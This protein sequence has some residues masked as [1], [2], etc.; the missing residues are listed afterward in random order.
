MKNLVCTPL[1][2]QLWPQLAQACGNLTLEGQEGWIYLLPTKEMLNCVEKKL[3]ETNGLIGCSR[4]NLFTL[5]GL[6]DYVLEFSD[7][8]LHSLEKTEALAVLAQVIRELSRE[9]KLHYFANAGDKLGYLEGL[10]SAIGE[11][12]RFLISPEQLNQIIV[13]PESAERLGEF[14]EIYRLYQQH[15]EEEHLAQQEDLYLKA[16]ELL[17]LEGS[18]LLSGFSSLV[19]SNY[20][21]F[22]PV[23]EKFLQQ[24]VALIPRV[25]INL[26][27]DRRNPEAYLLTAKTL[28]SL[29]GQGLDL[30]FIEEEHGNHLGCEIVENLFSGRKEVVE[31]KNR[32]LLTCYQS[33]EREIRSI[34]REIK[35]LILKENYAPEE[36]CILSRN[37]GD[38]AAGLLRI[39]R[40]YGIPLNYPQE[41]KLLFHPLI[42]ELLTLLQLKNDGLEQ[43]TGLSPFWSGDFSLP[44]TAECGQF[45]EAI[46]GFLSRIRLREELLKLHF[47]EQEVG[48][49]Q[50][51]KLDLTALSK[52]EEIVETFQTPIY[53]LFGEIS[54]VGFLEIFINRLDAVVLK[55]EEGESGGVRLLDPSSARGQEFNV[56]FLPGLEE[57]VFPRGYSSSWVVPESVRKKMKK[58]GLF[59]SGREESE[60]EE[61]FFFSAA[62]STASARIYLSYTEGEDRQ[63]SLSSWFI[64]EVKEVLTEKRF[65]C[66]PTGL[67]TIA[68]AASFRE[69]IGSLALVYDQGGKSVL[70]DLGSKLPKYFFSR[71]EAEAVRWSVKD[72][73][74]SHYNGSLEQPETR[75]KL[76]SIFNSRRVYSSGM[77]KDYAFCPFAF[78]A[79]RVLGLESED[80]PRELN[81]LQKG[82]IYHEVLFRFL[83]PYRGEGLKQ[84]RKQ[85]YF[86]QLG[87]VLEGV[88]AEEEYILLTESPRWP[89]QKQL[90]LKSLRLWLDGEL[91]NTAD[92]EAGFVP[93]CLEWSFGL[94]D[95]AEK[96]L[97][98][99]EE[100]AEIL[101]GGRIDRIDRS[102][103]GFYTVLDY[104]TSQIPKND[105]LLNL[106]DP[107]LPI[108][109]LAV[110]QLICREEELVV[111]GGYC[112][113][114]KGERD[115]GIWLAD[116]AR[117]FSRRKN[118]KVGNLTRE[119]WQ[120]FFDRLKQML[121]SYWSEIRKGRFY[122]KP[123]GECPTYCR[124]KQVCRYDP[125]Q[126]AELGGE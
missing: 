98:L 5:D 33:R 94:S 23:K 55:T 35:R 106:L 68:C 96:A 116:Y 13:Q 113:L 78:F 120:S 21:E 79:G 57:G 39:F 92:D 114:T 14:A 18:R 11:L 45:A 17:T 27:Y 1:G 24:V 61:M 19:M 118:K 66:L 8:R 101:L 46:R 15:L 119:E 31:N 9:G 99:S 107:Q 38:Y 22:T 63:G 65:P 93:V 16:A 75:E 26:S 122:L 102:S 62:V 37:T 4:I 6:V 67:Q 85:E 73:G 125:L 95:S 72:L 108:Y 40:E 52:L 103:E 51:L 50:K 28:S 30:I 58:S 90:L 110:E 34:A 100:G 105:E 20:F 7:C 47:E 56:V 44:E 25:E 80:D 71:V 12:K 3:W 111:G 86:A 112:T 43:Q 49:L 10:F 126:T 77:F 76:A 84:E 97:K 60:I 53:R 88:M 70:A 89:V 64:D 2:T 42:S 29:D 104:K 123:A 124:F 36:I 74:F 109:L 32:V 121:L 59:L 82:R 69:L 41:V 48:S 87:E 115:G 83:S 54:F 81:G 91:S 117:I